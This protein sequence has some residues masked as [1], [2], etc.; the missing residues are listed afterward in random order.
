VTLPEIGYYQLE[1]LLG[2]GG[3]GAVYLGVHRM[4]G[5]RVAVKML[6]ASLAERPDLNARFFNE[7]RTTSF[8]THPAIVRVFDVGKQPDGVAYMVM[9]LCDGPTLAQLMKKEARHRVKLGVLG[10]VAD[11]LT[12]A[13]AQGVVHRD[14][15]PDNV[16]VSRVG[17]VV[18]PRVLDFGIAKV[19]E[20]A[21]LSDA[22]AVK[23][24]TGTA[25]GTP[26]YMSPEQCRGMG[27]IT[28]ATD[29]YALG[30]MAYEALTGE[31]PFT[32]GV[33][34]VIV[35]HLT[36]P[37][38]ELDG[39]T[40][41]DLLPG[42]VPMI[43]AMLEKDPVARPTMT[44]VA[45]QLAAYVPDLQ[46]LDLEPPRHAAQVPIVAPTELGAATIVDASPSEPR[47]PERRLAWVAA[48]AAP[49]FALALVLVLRTPKPTVVA[50]P[51]AAIAQPVARVSD[52][53]PPLVPPPAVERPWRIESVPSDAEVYDGKKLL[54][55][56]PLDAPADAR[57]LTLRKRGFVEQLVAPAPGK[58]SSIHLPR[59][60]PRP[61]PRSGDS[62][63]VQAVH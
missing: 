24:R 44:E 32:G 30:I 31:V 61:T 55:H 49:F 27:G 25:M 18:Q 13:H 12:H 59:A 28:P 60:Q 62:F 4:T 22:H 19:L 17:D 8:L 34:E 6:R 56:T 7:A 29:V 39:V 9:E 10:V 43:R 45:Q 11:A 57:A 54:G 47:P 37:V 23:T 26:L 35:H 2:E 48:G 16:I 3:M 51:D 36:T 20:S 33:G 42:L 38:P 50:V 41:V 40:N 14:L 46:A 5:R 58:V 21:L 53:T 63:D 52:P 1:S 15:K